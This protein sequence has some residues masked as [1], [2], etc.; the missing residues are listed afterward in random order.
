MFTSGL[1]CNLKALEFQESDLK[2]LRVFEIGFGYWM[3]LIFLNEIEKHKRS[4]VLK[5]MNTLKSFKVHENKCSGIQRIKFS[6]FLQNVWKHP[7][8]SHCSVITFAHVHWATNAQWMSGLHLFSS[9]LALSGFS[10][11]ERV[12]TQNIAFNKHFAWLE[13]NSYKL[14]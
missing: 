13:V 6:K 4:K 8:F 9:S 3:S 2:A 5:Y 14:K 7:F 12:Y 10:A 1:I 11:C